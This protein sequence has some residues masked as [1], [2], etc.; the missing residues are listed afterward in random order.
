MWYQNVQFNVVI[1][2]M[3]FISDKSPL[4]LQHCIRIE[5]HEAITTK[6]TKT[7]T[8][9]SKESDT[10][11]C[12]YIIHRHS[13]GYRWLSLGSL[14]PWQSNNKGK[15]KWPMSDSQVEEWIGNSIT[16]VI[17]HFNHCKQRAVQCCSEL[18]ARLIESSMER[19]ASYDRTYYRRI[20]AVVYRH[21]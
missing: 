12:L 5:D 20:T 3:R 1:I 15:P 7:C 9:S 18:S 21:W 13:E 6:H 17:G 10:I 14:M 11:V 16:C 8:H 4:Q 2:I 19:N